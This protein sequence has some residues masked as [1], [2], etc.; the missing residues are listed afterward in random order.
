[1]NKSAKKSLKWKTENCV[2]WR[3]KNIELAECWENSERNQIERLHWRSSIAYMFITF[4]L[5]AEHFSS[6]SHFVNRMHFFPYSA[7]GKNANRVQMFF[8]LRERKKELEKE[9]ESC[10]MHRFFHKNITNENTFESS[11]AIKENL[12][13]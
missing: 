12:Y 13:F 7:Y 1:M 5:N 8:I 4:Q 2:M 6:S 3:K 9:R 10:E 11:N